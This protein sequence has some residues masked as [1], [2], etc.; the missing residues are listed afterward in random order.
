MNETGTRA[1][2]EPAVAGMFY[3]AQAGALEAE[4]D[5]AFEKA[6]QG[7]GMAMPR[8]VISPHAGLRFSG[9]LAARAWA[10]T[11]GAKA[12][13]IVIISPSHRH[14]FEGIALPSSSVF[15]M[16]GFEVEVDRA[17]CNA[18]A[19][20]GLARVVEAAH[21]REHGIEMQ[22]PFLNR[23]HPGARIVP[24]VTGRV[25]TRAVARAVDFLAGGEGP[26]PLFVLSSDLSHFLTL[27]NARTHDEETARLI[28]TGGWASLTPQHACGARAVAGYLASD[29]ARG[30]RAVRLAMANSADVTGDASRTVGYG[31]WALHDSDSTVVA[32]GHRTELLRAARQSLGSR[33]A[34]GRVPE[35]GLES[36]APP[37]RGHAA[38]FVT[39]QK[40]G[41]LRG[42]IGSLAAHRPLARDVVVNAAKAGFEDPRFAPVTARELG[43]V[44]LKIAV[45]SP[46]RPMAFADQADLEQQLGPGR[47]G[48]ILS[49]GGHRGIFLPMVWESLT[50]P[51]EFVNQ[52]K[53]KAG[54]PA[55]HWSGSL[56]IERFRAESFSEPDE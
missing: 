42:C 45:L 14:D 36:F 19:A 35:V 13:R 9:W 3:P 49:D 21:D 34:R 29:H 55:G 51:H 5:R 15:H 6:G 7:S 25:E 39:L 43:H 8:A 17:V 2:R 26:A 48:L 32:P 56:R 53:R 50:A 37:L 11:A 38:A 23:L 40:K 20:A 30:T 44:R 54:L 27:G 52:L 33:L 47:D 41:R 16:P 24:L 31:A 28:E 10:E 4:L 46:A 12:E 18:L 22:L 1:A